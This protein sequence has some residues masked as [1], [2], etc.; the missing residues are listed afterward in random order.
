MTLTT[1]TPAARRHAGVRF[2]QLNNGLWRITRDSGAVLG[3]VEQPD[4]AG[5]SGYRAKRLAAT[6]R[7][8]LPLGEFRSFDDALDCLRFG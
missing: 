7:S 6:G 2:V 8:F 4:A 3:Y 1:S 5:G